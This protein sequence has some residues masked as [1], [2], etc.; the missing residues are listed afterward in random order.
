MLLIANWSCSVS[1]D[2][3][4]R[5]VTIRRRHWL[6]VVMVVIR[7][8]FSVN[9]LGCWH[10]LVSVAR[11]LSVHSLIV[12]LVSWR[13]WR[14]AVLPPFPVAEDEV[15]GVNHSW[16]VAEKSEEDIYEKVGSTAPLEQHGDWRKEDGDDNL[17]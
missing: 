9:R 5:V 10:I 8:L 17:A 12:L 7:R 6:N 13:V 4:L 3:S 14:L 11:S 2:V 16:N 1:S 15:D